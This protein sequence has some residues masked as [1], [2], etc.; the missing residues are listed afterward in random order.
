MWS[1]LEARKDVILHEWKEET[2]VIGFD[3]QII[4]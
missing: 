2:E 3:I 1:R 4:I